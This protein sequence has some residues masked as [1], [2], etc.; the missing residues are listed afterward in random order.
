MFNLSSQ[1]KKTTLNTILLLANFA[2]I[3][4][5]LVSVFMFGSIDRGLSFI[6]GKGLTVDS[7][8]KSIGLIEKGQ[9]T[10]VTFYLRNSTSSLIRI[11]GSD[12][13]CACTVP[14]G[15]PLDLNPGETRELTVVVKTDQESPQFSQ[16][17]RLFTT[18]R[19]QPT[20]DLT[21][22]G[23]IKRTG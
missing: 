3:T 2:L 8:T 12:S 6:A 18:S 9:Q 4:A 21:I 16:S 20:L 10:S 13:S 5:A 15:L 23:T 22:L 7:S 1:S 14:D 11:V 19:R 17:I